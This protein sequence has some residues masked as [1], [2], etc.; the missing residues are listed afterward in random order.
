MKPV[1]VQGKNNT[2]SGNKAHFFELKIMSKFENAD[3]VVNTCILHQLDT[4]D[5]SDFM[6]LSNVKGGPSNKLK[7]LHEIRDKQLQQPLGS[8]HRMEDVCMQIP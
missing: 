2:S 3:A 6:V 7:Y 4:R 1:E 8:P 5:L